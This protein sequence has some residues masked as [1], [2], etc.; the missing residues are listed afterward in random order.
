MGARK[1]LIH[2]TMVERRIQIVKAQNS[3]GKKHK[4][5]Q[6]EKKVHVNKYTGQETVHSDKSKYALKQYIDN[7]LRFEASR[8]SKE[9]RISFAD[10]LEIAKKNMAERAKR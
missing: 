6:A 5:N 1:P 8:I 2:G 7:N 9:R 3:Q 4:G 10:A